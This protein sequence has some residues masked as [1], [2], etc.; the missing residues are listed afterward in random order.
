MTVLSRDFH[1]SRPDQHPYTPTPSPQGQIS[2]SHVILA[3]NPR[4]LRPRRAWNATFKKRL[5]VN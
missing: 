3:P 5:N 4:Q 1:F 2:S